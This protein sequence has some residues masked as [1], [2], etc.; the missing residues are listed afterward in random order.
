[1]VEAYGLAQMGQAPLLQPT[2]RC[3]AK[4]SP[5][6]RTVE[7]TVRTSNS[8]LLSRFCRVGAGLVEKDSDSVL[9]PFPSR[10]LSPARGSSP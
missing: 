7:T 10:R 1:M 6:P 9:N 2:K 5:A 4:P 3:K 8:G